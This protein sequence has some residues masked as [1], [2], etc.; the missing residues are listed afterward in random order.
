MN[1]A[2]TGT[3]PLAQY[4]VTGAVAA[5]AISAFTWIYRRLLSTQDKERE[6]LV[7]ELA[8]ERARSAAQLAEERARSDRLEGEL[9]RVNTMVQTQVLTVLSEAN[10]AVSDTIALLR[11]RR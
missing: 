8:E 2:E 1:L 11:G 7:A 6:R 10:R 3:D 9:T 5:I 4:G